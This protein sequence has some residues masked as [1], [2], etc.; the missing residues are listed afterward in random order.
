MERGWRLIYGVVTPV[1][2][3]C[4]VGSKYS[5]TTT[6]VVLPSVLG[7]QGNVCVCCHIVVN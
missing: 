4:A 2:L 6:R 5:V 7:I 1:L 3:R